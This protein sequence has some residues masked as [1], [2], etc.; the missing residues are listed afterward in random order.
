MSQ[1]NVELHRHAVEAFNTRDVEKFIALCDPEIELHSA[2]TVPGGA[3]Y[4]GHDGVRG[5]Y[6]DLADAFG[7]EVR[8]EP[9]AYFDLGEQT[10]LFYLLRGRGQQSGAE[11]A[12][13][14]AQVCKWRDG[15]RRLRK[16]L[17]PQRGRAQGPR[18]L[19]GCARA[20]RPLTESFRPARYCAGDVAGERGA[21]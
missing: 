5:W 12:M 9:E 18:R 15:P 6:R 19:R 3:T 16:G 14:G 13:P 2:V 20:D 17:C 7:D 11:V 10:L 4:H 21:F 8:L 1:E